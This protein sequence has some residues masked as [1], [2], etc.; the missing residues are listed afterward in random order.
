[1]FVCLFI[2]LSIRAKKQKH[3]FTRE[4]QFE[5]DETTVWIKWPLANTGPCHLRVAYT[6]SVAYSENRKFTSN[7]R[8]FDVG[9]ADI[10]HYHT[11]GSH[12]ALEP[13]D[14]RVIRH[15]LRKL[16]RFRR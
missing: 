8:T 3:N 13:N 2:C 14:M 1:M 15:R 5:K 7:C 12:L 11:G 16:T 10:V 9:D 6:C 4:I